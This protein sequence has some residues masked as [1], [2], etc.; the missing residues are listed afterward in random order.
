MNITITIPDEIVQSAHLTLTKV[1]QEIA[2]LFWKK[3]NFT[4]AQSLNTANLTLDELQVLQDVF[5]PFL[6]D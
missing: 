2:G 1:K 5:A 4:W 6:L 3:H